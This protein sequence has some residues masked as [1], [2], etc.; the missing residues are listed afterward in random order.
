MKEY[1]EPT[2]TIVE[3]SVKDIVIC[4]GGDPTV[5]GGDTGTNP[6]SIFTASIRGWNGERF[7]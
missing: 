4:S 7:D 6:E 2:A 3:F 1:Q 5:A